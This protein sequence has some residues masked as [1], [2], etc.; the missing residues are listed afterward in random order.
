[1]INLY[2]ACH[3][4]QRQ[5]GFTLVELA[6]VLIIAGL[7]LG[8]LFKGQ[9]L[10]L[11]ARVH[12]AVNSARGMEAALNSFQERYHYLPGDMPEAVAVRLGVAS[13]GGSRYGGDGDGRLDDGDFGEVSALWH[14]LAMA[15][16]IQGSYDSGATDAAGY[17]APR[18]A[19]D[20]R[21][22]GRL[23]IAT[24]DEYLGAS[25]SQ[26]AR[27]ALVFGH[28]F[29]AEAARLIDQKLDDGRPATGRVRASATGGVGANNYGGLAQSRQQ[30]VGGSGSDAHWLAGDD[31]DDCNL[32]MLL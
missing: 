25:G 13:Q 12:G 19:P 27:L 21:H 22:G 26:P 30:C 3:A 16:F 24:V 11:S 15:G 32:V 18:V 9:Q 28:G 8:G 23:M 4:A 14:H 1:M 10:L 2:R 31:A 6:M 5:R 17:M 7:L 20:N 29:S